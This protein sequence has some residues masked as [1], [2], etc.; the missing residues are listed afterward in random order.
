MSISKIKKERK[1]FVKRGFLLGGI[2]LILSGSAWA[3]QDRKMISIAT[4]GQP[5]PPRDRRLG[6]RSDRP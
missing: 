6:E 2:L 5:L 3:Q 4:G 1:R